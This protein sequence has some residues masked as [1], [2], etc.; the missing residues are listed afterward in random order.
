MDIVILLFVPVSSEVMSMLAPASLRAW[1]RVSKIYTQ[2]RNNQIG[3]IISSH[4]QRYGK[5][6]IRMHTHFSW[7]CTRERIS[8]HRLGLCLAC[9]DSGFQSARMNPHSPQCVRLPAAPDPCQHMISLRLLNLAILVSVYRYLTTGSFPSFSS[10]GFHLHFP[11][12]VI[13][14]TTFSYAPSI[15]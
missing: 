9:E 6:L 2:K 1:W 8:D 4:W 15:S 7:V 12:Y 13:K 11:Q 5:M 14:L 10:Y 3:L